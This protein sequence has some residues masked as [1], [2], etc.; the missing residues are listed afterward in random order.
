[1]L[2]LRIIRTEISEQTARNMQKV[3]SITVGGAHSLTNGVLNGK[4]NVEGASEHVRISD[5]N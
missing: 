2:G 1:M 5:F 4:N 3:A